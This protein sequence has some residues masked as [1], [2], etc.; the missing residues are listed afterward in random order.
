MTPLPNSG[1]FQL[2]T[3][4]MVI[5]RGD[6]AGQGRSGWIEAAPFRAGV[7]AMSMG[8]TRGCPV[9]RTPY[10]IVWSIGA[11]RS[12]D[13][14]VSRMASMSSSVLAGLSRSM[15]IEQLIASIGGVVNRS[16][17]P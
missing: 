4:P 16:E 15:G 3:L 10:G 2:I 12:I 5:Q 14:R 7:T 11:I 8:A 6:P 1:D 17:N 13:S 9:G